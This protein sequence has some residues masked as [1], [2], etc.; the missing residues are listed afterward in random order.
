MI[1]KFINIHKDKTAVICG[2]GPS[3]DSLHSDIFNKSEYVLFACNQSIV[4]IPRWDYFCVA[5]AAVCETN[6]LYEYACAHS[7]KIIFFGEF[8]PEQTESKSKNLDLKM[9]TLPRGSSKFNFSRSELIIGV[10]VV[11][12][13]ASFAYITG[14][15]RIFLAGVDLS[16]KSNRKYCKPVLNGGK[17][18][19]W[20]N[21]EQNIFVFNENKN[22]DNNLIES[23][24][25]WI[26]IKE[27]NPSI[28]FYNASGLDSRLADLFPTVSL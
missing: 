4:S 18:I 2:S 15:T 24:D 16:Y 14:C 9:Y 7:K 1:E 17:E 22:I 28:E 20:W 11:H 3:L 25:A 27:N 23:Y 21:L 5:D 8:S 19:R 26:K 6:D 10:D 13:A 12:V